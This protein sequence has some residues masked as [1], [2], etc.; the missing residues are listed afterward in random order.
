MCLRPSGVFA[1]FRALIAL[2]ICCVLSSCGGGESSKSPT[3]SY[4]TSEVD[5]REVPQHDFRQNAAICPSSSDSRHIVI[6]EGSAEA[7][8]QRRPTAGQPRRAPLPAIPASK[9]R[10]GAPPSLRATEVVIRN[11]VIHIFLSVLGP[12]LPPVPTGIP[13]EMVLFPQNP[14][15]DSVRKQSPHDSHQ[16]TF[17]LSYDIVRTCC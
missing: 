10:K 4:R 7:R 12:R 15:R 1:C 14:P 11:I 3:R 17:L 9:G 6:P 13:E 2:P 8:Y 16:G 5:S